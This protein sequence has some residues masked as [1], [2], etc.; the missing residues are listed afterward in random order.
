MQQGMS[1][2]TSIILM[3]YHSPASNAV[4]GFNVGYRYDLDNTE[5][6]GKPKISRSLLHNLIS[7]LSFY[8][9]PVLTSSLSNHVCSTSRKI[10]LNLKLSSINPMTKIESITIE[11][12]QKLLITS[13]SGSAHVFKSSQ[14]VYNNQ[15]P[16]PF[17][18]QY[19]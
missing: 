11:L 13:S 14:N 8:Q 5:I 18:I 10:Q 19:F 9:K 1:P 15:Q 16:S 12:K 17:C 6:Q 4:L 7:L 3:K 2:G